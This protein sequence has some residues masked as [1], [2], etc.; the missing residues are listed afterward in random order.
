MNMLNLEPR[1]LSKDQASKSR[2]LRVNRKVGQTRECRLKFSK[3]MRRCIGARKLFPIERQR[4]VSAVDWDET[5]GKVACLNSS[6][7]ALLT[8]ATWYARCTP[9][10]SADE[11][12]AVPGGGS[13]P[14]RRSSP[15]V[16]SPNRDMSTHAPRAA[17]SVAVAIARISDA[18]AGRF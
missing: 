7:S 16:I 6:R 11:M 5:A 13:S 3:A 1:V 12:P 14:R 9:A 10:G 2:P 18:L 15:R 8:H 17:S 4:T